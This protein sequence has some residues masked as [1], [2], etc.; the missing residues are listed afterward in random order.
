VKYLYGRTPNANEE[1][2][3]INAAHVF[4]D[5]LAMSQG[6]RYINAHNLN[7]PGA[8]H[9]TSDPDISGTE[10]PIALNSSGREVPP[11]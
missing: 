2:E 1:I 11:L 4:T 6:P 8:S 7:T 10:T 9:R 3:Y 5:M